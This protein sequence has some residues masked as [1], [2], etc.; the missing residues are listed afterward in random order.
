MRKNNSKLTF[1]KNRRTRLFSRR[2]L[3]ISKC[4][5]NSPDWAS[6]QKV[7]LPL[8]KHFED[9]QN[10]LS[11]LKH[12]FDIIGI[13]EHK[14]TEVLK[15]STSN[16]PGYT[17]WNRLEQ[18][19]AME[20]FFFVSNNLIYKLRPDLLSNEHGRLES[21]IFELIFPNKKYYLRCHL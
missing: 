10:F 21:T 18:A 1:T 15:N 4:S 8:S 7:R 13:S 3:K 19:P 12:S 9:L 2:R 14:R 5:T 16:L 11:L 20:Q 17:F 6:A